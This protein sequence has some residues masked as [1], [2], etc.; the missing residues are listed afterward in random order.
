MNSFKVGRTYPAV[1]RG[2]GVYNRIQVVART[3]DSITFRMVDP[4]CT[5]DLQLKYTA[6]IYLRSTCEVVRIVSTLGNAMV[7]AREEVSK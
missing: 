5:P 3:C 6:K 7:Y 1:R 4:K 2:P